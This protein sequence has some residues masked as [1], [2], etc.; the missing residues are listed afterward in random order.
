[1]NRRSIL[2]VAALGIL[3]ATGAVAAG[4][5]PLRFDAQSF[6][7]P[8]S[9]APAQLWRPA[10]A[11]PF[12][13]VLVLHGCGG[14]W[15]NQRSWA[16]RL[17]SWGYAAV[18]LDSFRPRN[19]RSTCNFGGNPVPRLRA[20]DAFNEIRDRH[21]DPD[22]QE[23][24][25]VLGRAV[26]ENGRGAGRHAACPGD[27]GLSRRRARLRRRRLAAFQQGSPD[28]R[29]SRSRR[30]FLCPD[31]GFPLGAAEGE[32]ITPLGAYE[33]LGFGPNPLTKLAFDCLGLNA[34][35]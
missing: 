3:A 32:L 33:L 25:L 6:G 31:P 1:M 35:G 30:R 34:S 15:D 5:E 4:S 23:R 9:S 19:V 7:G 22:R 16:A 18:V 26:R 28:R 11:G 21:V 17:A 2:I 24:R 29:K 8:N 27:Q 10:G 20:Q 12:P 13:A 14:I